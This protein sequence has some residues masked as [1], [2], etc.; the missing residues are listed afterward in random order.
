MHTLQRNLA[1]ALTAGD[2]LA[3]GRRMTEN[4]FV[5]WCDSET[6]AEWVD[7]EVIVMS[8]VSIEH[9]TLSS[10]LHHLLSA[11]VE[12]RDLGSVLEEPFQVR[13]TEQHR[14]RSPDIFFV[15]SSRQKLLK[16]HHLQGPPDLIIEIVSP[17]SLVRDW[18]EKYL[19]Y[20][21]AGVREYWIIDPISQRLEMYAL[22][23]KRRYARLEETDGRIRSKILKGFYLRHVWL[24]K[25]KR[26]KV[27]T[28]LREFKS[29]R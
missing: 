18:R 1:K 29:A 11:F 12:A 24:W 4:E 20:E 16:K 5:D 13:L 15:A 17:E 26:P 3:L 10:F 9:A 21:A 14:R 8:P 7:G 23:A 28:I 6:W 19:E 25:Q 27:A 22:T 2:P